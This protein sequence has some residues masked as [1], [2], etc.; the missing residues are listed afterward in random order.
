MAANEE[1]TTDGKTTQRAAGTG[2]RR[3]AVRQREVNGN[4]RFFLGSRSPGAAAP[5][6]DREFGTE[7]EAMVESLRSG[8]TYFAVSEFRATADLS[9][10][11]PQIRKEAVNGT[12]GAAS[13]HS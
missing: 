1:S 12:H 8:M 11:S 5:V 2:R 10:R 13:Q 3:S 4:T 6:L 9:G 7:N